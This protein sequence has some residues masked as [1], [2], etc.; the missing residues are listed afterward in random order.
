MPSLRGST[1]EPT[2][3]SHYQRLGVTPAASTEEIRAAYRAL[4]GRLHPD[5]QVGTTPA[6]RSLAERRMRE[7]N[8]SWHVLS[9]PTRRRVYDEQRRGD[10]SRRAPRPGTPTG[11]GVNRSDEPVGDLEGYRDE[12][13]D[14]LVDVLPPMRAFTAGVF[15]FLPWGVLLLVLG[16][17]F[18][19]TAYAGGN[20]S[21]VSPRPPDAA[22]GDCLDVS[23]GPSTTVVSC[24]GEHEYRVVERVASVSECPTGSEGRR[25]ASDGLFDCLVAGDSDR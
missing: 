20:D 4:A 17:I 8:E 13:D 10:A 11:P 18:V 15:G 22:V 19:V 1:E 23:P 7:V 9:D 6:E 5:R 12:V 14:D 24:T 25:F 3:T 16:L 2:T 21:S